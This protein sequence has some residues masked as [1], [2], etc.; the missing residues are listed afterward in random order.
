MRA[1]RMGLMVG[2]VLVAGVA[3]A[4]IEARREPTFKRDG[5]IHGYLL[6]PAGRGL[7][8]VV[9]LTTADGC[10]ISLHETDSHRRGRFDIDNVFP[11][12][13]KVQVESLGTVLGDLESPAP[14][15]VEVRAGR[16]SRPRLIAE[17]EGSTTTK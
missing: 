6:D 3:Q 12:R 5:H 7:T 4:K 17:C 10:R 1:L 13:Y 11:G 14:V 16:V 9:A 2:L 15:E 8:G